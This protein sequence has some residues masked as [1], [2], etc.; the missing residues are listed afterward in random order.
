VSIAMMHN[1]TIDWARGFNT[2]GHGNAAVDDLTLFQAASV[3]KAAV[4]DGVASSNY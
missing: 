3:S 1:G 4:G 2:S